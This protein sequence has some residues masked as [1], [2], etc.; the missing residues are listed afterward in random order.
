MQPRQ[1]YIL[2][3]SQVILLQAEDINTQRGLTVWVTAWKG[4]KKILWVY[5]LNIFPGQPLNQDGNRL[6]L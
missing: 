3:T 4:K 6:I 5:N 1:I 2:I